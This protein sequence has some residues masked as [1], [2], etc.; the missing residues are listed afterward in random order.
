MKSKMFKAIIIGSTG[1]TGRHVLNQLLTNVN[2][3]L[4]TTIGRRSSSDKVKNKKHR[5][6]II[7]SLKDLSSTKKYWMDNDV[8]FN[9]IGTTRK[10]SGTAKEFVNIEVGYSNKSA[11]MANQAG[12]SH[13][14]L[15]SA[16][17]ANPD[18]WAKKWIHPLFY[19]KTIGQKELT[20][21]KNFSFT[22]TSIFRPGMLLRLQG[23][24]NFFEYLAR[25]TGTGL[26]VDIL[27]SAMI[28]DA[29][30]VLEIDKKY[31][32]IFIGNK[33]I[34]KSINSN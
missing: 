4:V 14:S 6:V 23:K 30:K 16:G 19:I 1:A 34:I 11:E 7:P 17:G 12:I 10:K 22:K 9:C 13:V 18:V 21:T 5:D 27:A 20:I 32:N 2:C 24:K 3:E 31:S 26:S 29:E 15:I 8:F 28:R 33:N 25:S